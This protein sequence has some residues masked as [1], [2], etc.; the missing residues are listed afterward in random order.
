M[1]Q[2]ADGLPADR[3]YFSPFGVVCLLTFDVL[4]VLGIRWGSVSQRVGYRSAKSQPH[5]PD[6]Q[7]ADL[8]VC[9]A[10]G[11]DMVRA[12]GYFI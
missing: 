1:K 10:L 11:V 3:N 7:P 6:P 5:V 2:C 4:Q 8:L 9:V 12:Y